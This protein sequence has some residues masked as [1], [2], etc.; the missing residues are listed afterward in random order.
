MAAKNNALETALPVELLVAVFDS[1][2]VMV[3]LYSDSAAVEKSEPRA[4]D[5]VLSVSFEAS[6]GYSAEVYVMND[7]QNIDVYHN[8]VSY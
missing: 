6:E 8:P 4:N 1:T 3:D 7:R 2:G 5:T